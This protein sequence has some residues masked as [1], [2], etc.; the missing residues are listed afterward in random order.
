MKICNKQ[1]Y[2]TILG[3]RQ[4]YTYEEAN[5]TPE[6]RLLPLLQAHS[7]LCAIPLDEK[8][9]ILGLSKLIESKA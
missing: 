3:I 1:S 7:L 5:H 4:S 9:K 8:R 6:S 2:Q